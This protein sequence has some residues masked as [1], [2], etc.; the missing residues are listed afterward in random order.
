MINNRAC[1]VLL[2]ALLSRYISRILNFVKQIVHQYIWK[3]LFTPKVAHN[4][5]ALIK[6]EVPHLYL[7]VV[8]CCSGAL[9]YHGVV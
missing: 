4:M 5:P 6:Q 1:S 7:S 3:K 2:S 8:D 9:S